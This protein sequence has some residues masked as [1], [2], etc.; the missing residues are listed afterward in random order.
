MSHNP[1]KTRCWLLASPRSG[2][3]YLQYLLNLNAGVPLQ[4]HP[5]DRELS[6]FS[7][8]EH[9]NRS[10]C[11]SWEEFV[12]LDPVVSKI[13][14]HQF[15]HHLLRRKEFRE[16]FPGMRFLLLERRNVFAQAASLA[17]SNCTGIPHCSTDDD[18][19]AFREA[20]VEVD[21]DQLLR[22]HHAVL[23]YQKFWRNWLH[24]EPRLVVTYESLIENPQETIAIALDFLKVPY[25]E[26]SLEVPLFKLGHPQTKELV[27]RLRLLTAEPESVEQNE[28]PDFTNN[29][30]NTEVVHSP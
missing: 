28:P 21:D 1:W 18:L 25:T 2:S 20:S 11:Q 12:A 15:G 22:C 3:T 14:C 17:L 5:E 24:S 29:A 23:Q 13:H 9:L 30:L 16:Q 8:G 7:F 10:I 26:I 27:Q 4:P 19:L 6:R